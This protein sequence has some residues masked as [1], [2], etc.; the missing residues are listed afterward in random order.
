MLVSLFVRVIERNPTIKDLRERLKQS[1]EFSMNCGFTES[2]RIPSKAFS[3]RLIQKLQN[4][5]VFRETQDELIRQAFQEGFIDGTDVT[6]DATH[7]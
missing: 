2:D 1:T 5:V 4:S 6:M 7:I 3:S